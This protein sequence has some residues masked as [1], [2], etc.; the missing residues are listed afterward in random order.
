MKSIVKTA[1][2]FKLTPEEQ[3]TEAVKFLAEKEAAYE[4]CAAR[5]AADVKASFEA[6]EVVRRMERESVEHESD[7]EPVDNIALVAANATLTSAQAAESR[8]SE[9]CRRAE[10]KRDA[11]RRSV[12]IA[13]K[14]WLIEKL[15]G[16][17]GQFVLA[18]EKGGRKVLDEVI[19]QFGAESRALDGY[20]DLV[21]SIG[22]IRGAYDSFLS[23]FQ[24]YLRPPAAAPLKSVGTMVRF[25]Q[26]T[27]A[28]GKFASVGCYG[29]GETASFSYDVVRQ[30]IAGGVAEVI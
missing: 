28:E 11:A 20:A 7:G 19:A 3:H 24:Q 4:G 26:S 25:L 14:A 9:V 27:N 29:V 23:A 16:T 1:V 13:R 22:I 8:S 17:M 18:M 5:S 10:E 15:L 6:G 21:T 30:L 12:E 2:G